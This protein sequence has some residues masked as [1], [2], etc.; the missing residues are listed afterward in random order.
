M[1]FSILPFGALT[2]TLSASGISLTH[3]QILTIEDLHQYLTTTYPAIAQQKFRYAV[4]QEMVDSTHSL[5]D[6]DEIALL[7][8][9]SGG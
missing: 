6:G 1:R 4:N 5:Q 3:E 9:F 2:D 8:P 7:P